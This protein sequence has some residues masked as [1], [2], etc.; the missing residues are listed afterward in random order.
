MSALSAL[1]TQRQ[2]LTAKYSHG[3][4]VFMT[5]GGKV[6]NGIDVAELHEYIETVRR[7][8]A[9]A[10]RNPTFVARWRGGPRSEVRIGD[11]TLHVGGEGEPTAMQVLLASLGACDAEVVATHAALLGLEVEDLEVEVTGHYAIQRL[12]G[13]EGPTPG[14]GRVDYTVRLRAPGATEEQV[15][16]LREMCEKGSPVGASLGSAVPLTLEVEVEK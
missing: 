9:Q 2:E 7:D 4:P 5:K 12:L 14:Y 1:A 16:R 11:T 8:P 6:I 15:A 3:T 13:L 10:E